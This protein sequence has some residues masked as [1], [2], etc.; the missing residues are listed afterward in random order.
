MCSYKFVCGLDYYAWNCIASHIREIHY[1]QKF[2]NSSLCKEFF[3]H[4][5]N[6]Y[7]ICKFRA[8]GMDLGEVKGTLILMGLGR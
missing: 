1:L 7:F 3:H 5:N 8:L 2:C 6:P 4:A